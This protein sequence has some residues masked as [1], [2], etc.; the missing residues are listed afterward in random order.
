MGI[1][2]T[3][4]FTTSEGVPYDSVYVKLHTVICEFA[5]ATGETVNVSAH[6]LIFLNRQ[7]RD[8]GLAYAMQSPP[9]E[10]VHGFTIA[11]AELTQSLF[12]T[13]YSQYT[14]RLTASGYTVEDVIEV[15]QQSSE[16][17]QS[18]PPTLPTPSESAPQ[19]SPTELPQQ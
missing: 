8:Q 13:I 11:T 4:S 2:V 7:R 18:T 9:F 10:K 15:S 17:T 3:G 19:E 6:F 5:H 14:E 16:S 12:A 1:K